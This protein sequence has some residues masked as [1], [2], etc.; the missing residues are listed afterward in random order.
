M[1]ENK[2]GT[3]RDRRLVILYI[4]DI[5]RNFSSETHLLQ[6]EEILSILQE[7]YEVSYSAR[8]LHDFIRILQ[9]DGYPIVTKKVGCYLKVQPQEFTDAELR[10]M[11]DGVLFSRNISQKQATE[12][13]ERLLAKGSHIFKKKGKRLLNYCDTMPYSDNEQT[14]ENVGIV[15]KA[16][17]DKK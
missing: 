15:Q 1:R 5:L 14:L 17:A 8:S 11:A 3:A 7:K 6:R 4:L 13:I 12:L 16:I 2:R 10:M 9:E